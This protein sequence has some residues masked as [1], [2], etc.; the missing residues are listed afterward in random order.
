MPDSV[1]DLTIVEVQ[2]KINRKKVPTL[3]QTHEPQNCYAT[4][5]HTRTALP[6]TPFHMQAFSTYR[7][8]RRA[9]NKYLN[10]EAH[11]FKFNHFNI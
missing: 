10:G 1:V 3:T 2:N 11:F 9:H 7:V 8:H 4:K 6:D 5:L